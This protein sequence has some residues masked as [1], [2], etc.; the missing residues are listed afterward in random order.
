[1][2]KMMLY[3]R[4]ISYSNPWSALWMLNCIVYS[5]VIRW[6]IVSGIKPIRT[7]ITSMENRRGTWKQPKMAN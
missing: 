2:W 1:M 6:L 4:V 3:K 7:D 5:A